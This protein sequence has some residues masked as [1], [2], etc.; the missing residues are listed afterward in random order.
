MENVPIQQ[1]NKAKP[2]EDEMHKN[3]HRIAQRYKKKQENAIIKSQLLKLSSTV[4][5]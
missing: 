2:I 3:E 4:T 1:G 5:K